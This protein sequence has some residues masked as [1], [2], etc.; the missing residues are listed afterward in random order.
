MTAPM[1]RKLQ[2]L[3]A[4]GHLLTKEQLHLLLRVMT[5]HDFSEGPGAS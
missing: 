5:G 3:A 2:A 4:H 1:S